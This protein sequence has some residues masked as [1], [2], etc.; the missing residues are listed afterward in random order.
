[1]GAITSAILGFIEEGY[2]FC[3]LSN[4]D[5]KSLDENT[6]RYLADKIKIYTLPTIPDGIIYAKN[7]RPDWEGLEPCQP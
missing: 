7:E 5:W 3:I 4:A 2:R 6:K 1:M